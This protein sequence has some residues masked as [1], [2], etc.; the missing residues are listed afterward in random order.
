MIAFDVTRVKALSASLSLPAVCGT[1]SRADPGLFTSS[2]GDYAANVYCVPAVLRMN[3]L[4]IALLKATTA[5]NPV[6]W[7]GTI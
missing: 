2:G 1:R 6:Q 7:A 5:S 4:G 3:S